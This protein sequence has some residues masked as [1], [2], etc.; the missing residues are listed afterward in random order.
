MEL[1]IHTKDIDVYRGKNKKKERFL[2][3][4]DKKNH[5]K[6]RF[7]IDTGLYKRSGVFDEDGFDTGKDPWMSSMPE[8][9]DV[10]ILGHCEHGR[11]G[12]CMKSGIECYQNG[13]GMHQP[14]MSLENFKRIVDECKGRVFQFALGGRGDV[15]QHENFE[16]I[17]QY[18]KENDIVPNFTTSGLGMTHEIAAICKKYCGAVA[19]SDHE[20]DYTEKAL[21]YLHG[22]VKM[23]ISRYGI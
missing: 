6:S 20:A 3:K 5:F 19:V 21:N 12:L 22:F 23:M 18:C 2:E 15:D 9:I 17:L 4:I 7:Y 8:L 11:T 14:N 1:I 13:L 10:G 16:E